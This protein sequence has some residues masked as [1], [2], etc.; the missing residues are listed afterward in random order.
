[1]GEGLT[2]MISILDPKF[3]PHAEDWSLSDGEHCTKQTGEP[4][5]RS[6]S[7]V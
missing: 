6:E 4:S 1:M 7:V 3:F 5:A 2:L